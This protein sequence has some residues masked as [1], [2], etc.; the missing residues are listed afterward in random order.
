MDTTIMKKARSAY[1]LYSIDKDVRNKVVKANP[2]AKLGE[3][4][5][6]IGKQWKGLSDKQKKKYVDAS[7]KEKKEVE[8]LKAEKPE[9][10]VVKET[11]TK[12]K[13]KVV[14]KNKPKRPP[15]AYMLFSKDAREEVKKEHPDLKSVAEVSKKIGEKWKKVSA[16]KKKKYEEEANKAKKEYEKAMKSYVPP[17]VEDG[18][19][20]EPKAKKVKKPRAKSAYILF[21]MDERKR[22]KKEK[23][24]L[25]F[26]DMTKELA[27]NWN[28]LSAAKKKPYEEASAKEKK[29]L[30]T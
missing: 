27:K 18:D 28:A 29:A 12:K 16:S 14:D 15:N 25:S 30:A 21:T 13:K 5:K 9:L 26:T 3:I 6:L 22:L 17:P 24:D 1:I 11:S 10:F 19:E 8:K 23:P 2:D 4:S 7:E 20:E